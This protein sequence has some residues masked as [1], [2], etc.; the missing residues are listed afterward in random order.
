MP[1]H[2]GP[3]IN[4]IEVVTDS[5]ERKHAKTPMNL[6]KGYL[7]ECG[8]L[9]ERNEAFE[10]TV[11]KLRDQGRLQLGPYFE[12]TCVATRK[13]KAWVPPIQETS[14]NRE[15]EHG[16]HMATISNKVNAKRANKFIR[17][18]APGEELKIWVAVEIPEI[19][20]FPK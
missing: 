10:R 16:R 1:P 6:L 15:I 13:G 20:F 5:G 8:F 2:D 14:A 3:T 17:E 12:E 19:F 18:C 11:Q 4:A 9:L 7:F